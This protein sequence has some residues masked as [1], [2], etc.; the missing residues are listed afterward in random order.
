MDDEFGN[1]TIC[2]DYIKK[3]MSYLEICKHQLCFC[4]CPFE[5][6]HPHFTNRLELDYSHQLD[7][8]RLIREQ[9]PHLP[10]DLVDHIEYLSYMSGY[11]HIS[12][13]FIAKPPQQMYS[14]WMP[15]VS[16]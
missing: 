5:N 3:Y 2:S 13:S 11:Q 12:E 6:V 7:L 16:R 9:F 14:E 8:Y 4:Y 1:I 10:I 15:V